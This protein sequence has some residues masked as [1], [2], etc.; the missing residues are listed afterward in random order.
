MIT[1]QDLLEKLY[2]MPPLERMKPVQL[3]DYNNDETHEAIDFIPCQTDAGQQ[4]QIGF[5]APQD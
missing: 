1:F 3:R 2:E 4:W 5:N